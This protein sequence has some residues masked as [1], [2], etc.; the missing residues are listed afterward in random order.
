[1]QNIFLCNS[2]TETFKEVNENLFPEAPIRCTFEDCRMPVL[3]RKSTCSVPTL[4]V[5]ELFQ[6]HR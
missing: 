3:F 1:M 5:M 4:F 6:P 2:R